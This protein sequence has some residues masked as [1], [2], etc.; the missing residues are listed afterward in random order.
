MKRILH[1]VL[2]VM[3]VA[4]MIAGCQN[5]SAPIVA[6]NSPSPAD[7]GPANLVL[8]PGATL[9]SANFYVYVEETPGEPVNIHRITAAWDELTVTWN[10][11]AAAYAL[12]IYGSFTPADPGWYATDVTALVAE[13]MDGT[14]DNYG[15]LL[16]QVE[17]NYPRTFYTSREAAENNPYL[18]FCYE[19]DGDEYCENIV[20]MA[21]AYIHE[22]N[23]D[24]SAGP[25][26]YLN[27]G[28]LDETDL[29]KQAMLLFEMPTIEPEL[30]AIGDFVWHDMDMDGIQDEGEPG[31][32]GVT[33]ELYNCRD[34]YLD[35][36]M[37]DANGMYLF[38]ELMAGDYYVKFMLP[39]GYVFTMQ[40]AGMDD[41]LDSDADPT[42]GMTVCTTLDE[43]ETD[44]TWDA[45]MYMPPMEGCTHTIGYWKTHAGFGPQDDVVSQY[46]PI[47]LGTDGGDKS[48]PV[49]T[50]AIAV[51]VLKMKTYGHPSNGITK[52]YAQLLGAK[53]SIA[54]GA[55]PDDV[56]DII[57]MAD[58]FLAMYDY[59]DWNM[60]EMED[61]NM[62]NSWKDMLDDYNNGI[63]GPGHCDDRTMTTTM[64]SV[65]PN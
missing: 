1:S 28:W 14:Y 20:A 24:W 54:D 41:A 16:D 2:L 3:A 12:D 7:F 59:T 5:D 50:A 31:I 11:F 19:Y 38:D 65:S 29:E 43:G 22:A 39:M 51:D 63:I 55:S 37:T 10:S 23:P 4:L 40:D 15:L 18:E 8:P 30:A 64:T 33:V 17:K 36:M 58:E 56:S 9:T 26:E 62:V 47:W 25:T 32:E 35:E 52:L 44:L 60:L 61:L 42:T 46:L 48:V 45:G 21:D 34:E 27:T 53:L 49:T 6:D 13:W 57:D